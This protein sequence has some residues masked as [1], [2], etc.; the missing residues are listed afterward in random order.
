MKTEEKI[1]RDR[2]FYL[3]LP[4]IALP[5]LVLLFWI[6]GG[7]SG[8]AGQDMDQ[9]TAALNTELPGAN[10]AN[11]PKDKLSYYELAE[12]DSAKLLEQMKLDTNYRYGSG[13]VANPYGDHRANQIYQGLND[14]ERQ[15]QSGYQQPAHQWSEPVSY[16]NRSSYNG[17]SH[18][19]SNYDAA[20]QSA[21]INQL[22]QSQADPELDQLNTLLDKVMEIQNPELANERLRESSSKRRGE[23]FAVSRKAKGNKVTH[24]GQKQ[25]KD[26]SNGFYSLDQGGFADIENN[27]IRAVVH[28]DQ[29]V[30]NGSTIKMRLIDDVYINGVQIPKDHFVFGSAQLS[31]ERLGI[32][33]ESV[34]YG[35]SLFPVDLM[36]FDMDGIDGVHVPGSITRDVA[37]QSA[38]R[39]MQSISLS[40]LDPSWGS[41]AAGA[42]VEMIKGL[43]SKKAKL[44][45]VKVKAGYQI[46]LR[47]EK[48]KQ[49]SSM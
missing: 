4:L 6:L 32:R 11:Q 14:L 23:V 18:G 37:K 40:G 48:Q 45:R 24:L 46:L 1:A 44:I 38:D 15:I 33:I 49:N 13:H 10:N 47:D 27:A 30:V 3:V 5:F 26:S 9:H 35:S 2:K 41:Q 31:G 29:V 20:Y 19:T 17:G 22:A 8:S 36:V 42:G 34:R 21:Y 12:K 16:Q 28:E 39:P 25:E 7:G 43:F